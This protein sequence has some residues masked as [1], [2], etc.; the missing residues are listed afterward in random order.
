MAAV[1]DRAGDL[2]V[3]VIDVHVD[4][5]RVVVAHAVLECVLHED[6]QQQRRNGD[7]RRQVVRILHPDVHVVGVADAHQP[8][9]IL[10]ELNVLVER[11]DFASRIVEH[12]AH[13]LRKLDHGVFCIF[14]VD[15]DQR[16]D[17]VERVHEEVGID[18]VL[19]I[20]HF[21]LHVLLFEL[22]HLLFV[23]YRL[24][25][26]LDARIG[27]RHEK[28]QN[29]VPVHFQIG[30]RRLA[31]LDELVFGE[32]REEQ[33]V[34]DVL[35]VEVHEPERADDQRQIGYQILPILVLEHEP[36]RD[37]AV[38]DDEYDEVG[39]DLAPCDQYVFPADVKL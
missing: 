7:L 10:D 34:G 4:E 31:V 30:E 29:H 1:A 37:D 26:E 21:G 14:R 9:V 39:R 32:V 13:H 15:V 25:H 8:D 33:A 28:S 11:D 19:Q 38:V 27:P 16:M 35:F 5:R 20:I 17:V 3:G 18:L 23:A 24:V 6:D 36:R 22:L 2:A 12:V